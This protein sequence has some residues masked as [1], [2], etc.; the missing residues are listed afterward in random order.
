MY[1]SWIQA[2]SNFGNVPK[3][4]WSFEGKELWSLNSD[5]SIW[6]EQS[7]KLYNKYHCEGERSSCS[8]LKFTVSGHSYFS[9]C[10]NSIPQIILSQTLTVS[11]QERKLVVQNQSSFSVYPLMP[12]GVMAHALHPFCSKSPSD[13]EQKTQSGCGFGEGADLFITQQSV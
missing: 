3:H 10:I 8:L 2:F 11:F 13:S 12:K 4:I 9:D 1:L 6:K 7:C 5:S